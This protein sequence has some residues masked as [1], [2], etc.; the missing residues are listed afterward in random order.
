MN[1]LSRESLSEVLNALGRAEGLLGPAPHSV[2]RDV[3]KE[4]AAARDLLEET[5]PGGFFTCCEACELPIGNDEDHASGGEDGVTI[6]GDCL[7]KYSDA[8]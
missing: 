1:T 7:R 3:I 4:L 5:L 6:C 8:A 2:A